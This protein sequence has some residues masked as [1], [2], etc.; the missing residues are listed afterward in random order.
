[1]DGIWLYDVVNP[2]QDYTTSLIGVL[3]LPCPS[4]HVYD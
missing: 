4:N 1:M 3:P 2:G